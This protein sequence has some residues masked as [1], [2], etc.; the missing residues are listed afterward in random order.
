[1]THSDAGTVESVWRP[2]P[3][4]ARMLAGVV[5]ALALAGG[6]VVAVM[7]MGLAPRPVWVVFGCQM[8]VVLAGV[9]G[10]GIARGKFNEGQGLALASVG[11]TLLAAGLMTWLGTRQGVALYSEKVVSLKPLVGGLALAGLTMGGLAAYAVLRRTSQGRTYAVRAV[12]SGVMLAAVAGGLWMG[13]GAMDSL[14]PVV[15][16]LVVVV[17]SVAV[18]VLFCAAG[19]CAIRAFECGRTDD[20]RAG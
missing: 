7:A 3:G 14:G 17:G 1:M 20:A 8:L 9:I 18:L 11:G 16:G 4:W 13:R 19:H 12:V 5:S 15:K 6:L 10:L 2:M